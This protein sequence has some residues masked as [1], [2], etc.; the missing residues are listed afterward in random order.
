MFYHMTGVILITLEKR[1]M[2]TTKDRSELHT[3]IKVFLEEIGE[4]VK[5]YLE[6]KHKEGRKIPDPAEDGEDDNESRRILQSK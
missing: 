2:R 3:D 4:V 1:K 5:E 6:T